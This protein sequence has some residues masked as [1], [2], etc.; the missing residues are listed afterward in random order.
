[1]GQ[2]GD[3]W[4]VG[5]S[6][7]S[8]PLLLA[9]CADCAHCSS[10]HTS[11]G[12]RAGMDCYR[13]WWSIVGRA[14]SRLDRQLVLGTGSCFL[15]LDAGASSAHLPRLPRY[16]LAWKTKLGI[17]AIPEQCFRLP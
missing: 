4:F 16:A 15:F 7:N 6:G 13:Y 2:Y 5:L 14:L 8:S 3:F 1:M 9:L 12:G 10:E 17:T 11:R